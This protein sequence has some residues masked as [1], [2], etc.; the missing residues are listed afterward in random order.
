MQH[1]K[2]G[3]VMM[4][5]GALMVAVQKAGYSLGSAQADSYAAI[6]V[7]WLIGKA[8]TQMKLWGWLGAAQEGD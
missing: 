2:D 1:I 3:F 7:A 6:V 8:Q 5:S 4:I